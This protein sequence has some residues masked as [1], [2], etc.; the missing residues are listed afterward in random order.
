M[1]GIILPDRLQ[2]CTDGTEARAP[3]P[4]KPVTHGLRFSG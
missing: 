3:C 1:I 4:S 2:N